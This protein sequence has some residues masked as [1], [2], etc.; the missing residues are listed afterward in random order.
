M[1]PKHKQ[2]ATT[3][4]AKHEQGVLRHTTQDLQL[5]EQEWQP[6]QQ[7]LLELSTSR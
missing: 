2:S 3:G 6:Q 1:A 4:M 7:C 5:K